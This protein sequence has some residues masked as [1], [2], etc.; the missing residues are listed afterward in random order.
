[1]AKPVDPLYAP[2][3]GQSIPH[4]NRFPGSDTPAAVQALA[5]GRRIQMTLADED[6]T[7]MEEYGEFSRNC[8]TY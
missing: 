4:P 6:D 5:N 2:D 1:M 7:D 8:N 3:D